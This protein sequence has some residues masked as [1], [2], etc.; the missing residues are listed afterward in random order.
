MH[1]SNLLKFLLTGALALWL[2]VGSLTMGQGI[3]TSGVSGTVTDKQG[4]PVGGATVTIVH[5]PSGTRSTATTRANGQ[6]N[7]SGLRIGGPYTVAVGSVGDLKAE[8]QSG[9][10][11]DLSSNQKVD[12]TL[13]SGVVQ[14]DAFTVAETRDTTFG[15]GKMGSGSNFNEEALTNTASV[16]RNVQDVAKNDSRFYL[17]SLDQG[18]Q[19]S[20]QGQNFRF[21]TFLIDGVQA[22]DSFGLASN[23][24]PSLR[25]PIPLEALEAINIELNP[26]DVRKA[27]FTGALI[28]AVTKSGTNEFHGMVYYE[29]T[30][31]DMRAK[32]PNTDVRDIFKERTWGLTLGG[33]II[34][35]KLFFFGSYDD[36]SRVSSPPSQ[37]FS[38]TGST[39]DTDITARAKVLNFDPGSFGALNT[40]FQKTYIGKLDW[41]ISNNHRASLTYRKND[42]QDTVFSNFTSSTSTSYSS[43]WYDQPRLTESYTAKLFSNWTPDLSTELSYSTTKSD[44]SPSSRSPSAFPEIIIQNVSGTRVSNN[45][46]MTGTVYM[47]TE[48]SRQLNYIKTDTKDASFAVNYSMGDHTFTVGTDYQK[49]EIENAF[50]QAF[51]GQYTF[52]SIANWQAGIASTFAQAIYAPGT[53]AIDAVSIFG[54][55]SYG[56]Y[57]QDSWRPNSRLNIVAG[58]RLDWLDFGND[59]IPVPTTPNYSEASF[60]TA[61]GIPSNTSASG[62]YTVGPRVGFT[63]ELDTTRKTQLRGGVGLFQGRSPAVYL[64]NA[65]SNRGVSA[66]ITNSNVTF[67]P[68]GSVS[69]AFPAS[70]L[71]IVNVTDPDFKQ[72]VTWK[73]NVAIDHTLPF[74]GLIFTMEASLLKVDSALHTINLNLRETGLMPDGRIRYAGAPTNTTSGARGSSNNNNYTNVAHYLNAGFADVYKL[75]NSSKGGGKDFTISLRKPMKKNWEASLSVTHSDYTEVSPSTSST[76]VSNYNNRAVFN[77]N[78]DVDSTSNTNIKDRVVLMATRKFEFIKGYPTTVAAVYEAR[79]GHPYSWVFYG[80]A[81][82]DGF[83]FNDLLYVPSGEN[84]SR[85]RWTST[86]E[87]DNFFA[88]ARSNGL[89]KYANGVAPRNSETSPWTQTMDLKFTQKISIYKNLSTELYLNV[90]NIG[91]MLNKKWG[92]LEEV[93]FS[94][95]RAVVGATYDAVLNQYVYTFNTTTLNP[96]P[97]TARDT[98]E[99]RWQ[100]QAGAR[101]SF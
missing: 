83:T 3:T 88:F 29:K 13:G 39:S 95:K 8:S 2:A 99:S 18:G 4:N 48:F 16:R 34:K 85:V 100:V 25:G 38:I 54:L 65:Y 35:D 10:Y 66:R 62:N 14:L 12:F 7:Q 23:G 64:S 82:G 63:Y 81:N 41:N 79:T 36:F 69:G 42:G 67:S 56:V 90:I 49:V 71:A 58:L 21:N 80:D 9:I 60:R 11:L 72:P 22:N 43:N 96:V 15:T 37:V 26:Y 89:M 5:E 51:L 6:F 40:P 46:P 20:A 57:A 97:I 74:G 77:P 61:F 70:A 33:P 68:T 24:F 47:G 98:P 44:G 53:S 1:K 31:Q 84:D 93:P 76:A 55:S 45:T 50:L 30:D 17:G 73:S 28:N 92:L 78:E 75:T 27:G 19:L 59:P 32:N 91:N 87:R 101:I 86:T 94:Y 52:S